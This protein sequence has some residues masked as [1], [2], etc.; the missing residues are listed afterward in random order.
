[1][2][3]ADARVAAVI[4]TVTMITERYSLG[5]YLKE[6]HLDAAVLQILSQHYLTRKN[7]TDKISEAISEAD[8][9]II[10]SGIAI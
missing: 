4:P 10:C 5:A 1:L 3:F 6:C 9:K 8:R 7:A 2:D